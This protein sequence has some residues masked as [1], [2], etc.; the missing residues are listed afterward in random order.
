MT[1][2]LL[3]AAALVI[4]GG[5]LV[6]AR[7]VSP[8]GLLAALFWPD[9]KLDSIIVWVL[10]LPRSLAA[11]VGGAGLGVSGYILQTLTRNPLA[12]PDLAGVMSGAVAPIAFC[13]VFLPWLS[14]L[15]Y[16][17][18]GVAGGLMAALVTF[19]IARGGSGQPLHLALGGISVSLVLGALTT[20]MLIRTG[21]Q[22]ASLMF[23]VSGG[24]AG[25]TWFQLE[26]LLLW[27]AA[28]AV[29]A[30]ASH[31][32][33]GL[34][35]LSE[36][37]AAGMGLNLALWKPLLL[38]FSVLPVAGVAAVAGPV[39]F[40]GLAAPHIARL[41][42]PEG[43]GWT[44]ALTAALGGFMVVTADILAR[45]VA[46]PRELPVGIFTALIGGPVFIYLVQR[47]GF[48]AKAGAQR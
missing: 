8:Q 40:V 30:L 31:R 36:D 23:W 10:R 14:P 11:W 12:G 19:W 44:T 9:G 33:L 7:P 48:S 4:A 37:V 39:A 34:M 32:V 6:G 3:V 28:G 1:I 42:R 22:A 2:I 24:F 17:F 18:I 41:L 29:G 45:S 13:F 47:S 21:P 15:L 27:V 26:Y 25:R 46:V 43:P 35:A 16:P 5:L 38:F 20:Y